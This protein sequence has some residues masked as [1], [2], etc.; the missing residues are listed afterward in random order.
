VIGGWL[1]PAG[2]VGGD[3]A[4]TPAGAV[5]APPGAQTK[6]PDQGT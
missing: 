4:D 6:A 5:D 1:V 3:L 2:T